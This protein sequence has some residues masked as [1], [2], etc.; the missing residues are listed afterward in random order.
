MQNPVKKTGLPVWAQALIWLSVAGVL[1]VIAWTMGS[2]IIEF[3][4][5]IVKAGANTAKDAAD[6]TDTAEDTAT[7]SIKTLFGSDDYHIDMSGVSGFKKGNWNRLMNSGGSNPLS[8]SY[9]VQAAS[10]ANPGPT[11]VAKLAQDMRNA[12]QQPLLPFEKKDPQAII[13]AYLAIP[14]KDNVNLVYKAFNDTKAGLMESP[15]DKDMANY[16]LMTEFDD[17]LRDIVASIILSKPVSS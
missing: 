12:L 2:K 17:N 8:L 11:A 13:N 9:Q 6:I 15:P 4:E 7:V 14:D 3:F 1:V 5:S 10:F 16:G